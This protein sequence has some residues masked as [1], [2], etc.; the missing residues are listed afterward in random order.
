M[1]NPIKTTDFDAIKL[2]LASP[3]VIT[4]WSYGH[5]V[6]PETINYRTQK[7]EKD[8]L[9][10]EKIFGPSKDW[11]CY[12]GKY[13]KIRYKGIICD[14]C[15]VEVTRSQVR[16][17]RMGHIV[18]ESPCTHIWFLRG[19]SSKVGLILDL[20][21]QAL[22]KVVYFASF[23]VTA[24]DEDLKNATVEQIKNEFKQK[25][26]SIESDFANQTRAIKDHK[27]KLMHEGMSAIEADAKIAADIEALDKVKEEKMENLQDALETAQREL[28]ELKPLLIISETAYQ[29]LSLKY[30]HIFEA[31]IGAEAIRKLLEKIDIE[32]TIT[33]LEN[34]LIEAID[35]KKEKLMR[36]L[37]L[38]K[39]LRAN[40]IKP[41]WMILTVLPVIPP[42]LRPMVALDGGRFATS[43]LN[44]LYRRVINR[45]NRLRQLIDLN[46]PEVIQRNEKRM[47]Q[48]AVDAL[49]DNS[50][51]HGKTVIASTGQKR[52]LK[53][54]ADSLKGK[55]G[56][57]RQNL[58]GKRIDYSGRSVIVVNPKLKLDQCGLPKLMAI[59]LFKP[60]IISKLIEKEVVHN[61]RSASR[62]IESGA[63]IVWDIL[64]KIID[65]AYVMLNRAPTLH[66]LGIQAFKP[67]LIEG[68]A[69]QIHPLV[70]SAFNADFDGDQMAVHVPLTKEAVDEAKNIMLSAKNL[71]KPAT[72]DP[73]VAPGQDIVWGTYYI[74]N[75]VKSSIEEK[76]IKRFSSGEEARLAYES[77]VIKLHDPIFVKLENIG[78]TKT[79]VG[80]II[81]NDILPEKLRFVNHVVDKGKLK[82]L[83][84]LCYRYYGPKQ[85]G[86]FLD[87][88]K[89]KSFSYITK[90]GLSWGMGDL[91]R[92][93][94]KDVLISD[95]QE[96]VE[97]IQD[98]YDEGLL[99]DSERYAKVIELWSGVKERVTD[100]CKKGLPKD[101]PVFSMIDS[102]ARGSWAQLTQILGMKGLVTSPSGDIIELPVKGNFKRG[103]DV[104][105]Y[106]IS[107]HGV[108][109]GLS[110]TALRT[111]NAGYLT[112]R[113]V[114]VSQDIIITDDDCGD[115]EG[116]VFTK[117][118]S[119]NMG[120]TLMDRIL[121][122]YLADD[123][124]NVK[125][126]VLVPKGTL[127]VED[128]IE[129]IQ[130]EE[131]NEACIRSV[132]SCKL[133]RGVCTHCY[134]WDL[135]HN[136]EVSLGTAVG[137]IAA[138]SIGEP[139][140]QLTMRTFHS[141]GVAGGEDITQ[142]LPRVEEIFECRPPKRK[143]F[144][145]DVDGLVSIEAGQRTIEDETGKTTVSNPQV[146]I[147]KINYDGID[148]DKYY[149]AETIKEAQ[150][151]AASD[152]KNSGIKTKGKKSAEAFEPKIEVKEGD[153]VSAGTRLFT[154]GDIVV[155][156][157][158]G[159]V[160]EIDEKSVKIK[161]ETKKVK[162]FIVPK[163]MSIMVQAG[164][165]VKKGDQLTDGSMDLQQLFTLKD[166]LSTQRYII[167]E[168]QNVYS[169]Q[170]QPLNDKHIEIIAKQMFSRFYIS[171]TIDSDLLPGEIVEGSVLARARRKNNK[172][173]KATR[174]LMGIT[175]ASLST[176]SFLS[177]ASFQETARV[178]I[179]SA[180]TGKIDY[181]EGLKE[182]VIIGRLIPAGTGY[183]GNRERKIY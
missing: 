73:V 60:F 180:V 79:T 10:C 33:R 1:L 40:D 78:V 94:E 172:E 36:R 21:M 70:C 55:Q 106:F 7:P 16:R 81:F 154:A 74:T 131:V 169:S 47:L 64:E 140:T 157:N 72:G 118:D 3:E 177:A 126:K 97:K 63:D 174:L 120:T 146:K 25:K 137:I 104:L 66:R 4:K 115:T 162:E 83:V 26:K 145:S 32:K 156:A 65:G 45:N 113:L 117:I 144:I 109:K 34:E 103:F 135:G 132:L 119:E 30:G 122:R 29:N 151:K 8:G 61:V 17:E 82:N 121:G 28:K 9:F 108:R 102:G 153:K 52:M 80:R 101:G 163:G 116:L 58:L 12:C 38:C 51:R 22:E 67:I 138:Q 84:K 98:Q 42:D 160:V 127:M 166:R 71:L 54:L 123:L 99:T 20:S 56:R 69:I 11:E 128:T 125:G 150:Q 129:S 107:S 62:F 87:D 5:V 183:K 158:N 88:L 53:S 49:I 168:I 149:F 43:D 159:G 179:E 90:S 95:T 91:P 143:A 31:G 130:D 161:V 100:I 141:G 37:K 152:K 59:E 86:E 13:K 133:D 176:D 68:K 92:F 75:E 111:A 178:L 170:G 114:D 15:G 136:K 148:V 93:E 2:K 175:K 57:F 76:N 171:E 105:E 24:V 124:K 96:M 23:I 139:G 173:I 85:T 48:E 39:S 167:K 134:G 46:A 89:E 50:A 110:D 14:K 112:R 155:I 164:E 142:G 19:L 27:A 182:N 44:D 35:S 77:K 147:L 18:L 165:E 181:L 41:E 6:R